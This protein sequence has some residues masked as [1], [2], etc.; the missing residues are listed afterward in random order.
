MDF[1]FISRIAFNKLVCHLILHIE[2]ITTAGWMLGVR[3]HSPFNLISLKAF[4]LIYFHS[5]IYKQY[6]QYL[7]VSL[8]TYSYYLLYCILYQVCLDSVHYMISLESCPLLWVVFQHFN[9]FKII[10]DKHIF[11]Y[12]FNIFLYSIFSHYLALFLFYYWY[13]TFPFNWVISLFILQGN[14]FW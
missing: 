10:T 3:W 11:L 1:M 14:N 5:N 6:L 9:C 13:S 7:C 8:I 2:H 4:M 12:I